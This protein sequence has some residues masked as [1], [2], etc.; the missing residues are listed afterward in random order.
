MTERPILFSGEMVRSIR[1]GRKTQTRRVGSF[2]KNDA[3]ELGV[4]YIGHAT[5]GTVAQATYRAFPKGGTAR[6]ALCEC[7]YGIPG[8]R[9]WVRET[10]LNNA[11]A[12][13][14]PVCF[15]R[16]DDADK[17]TDRKWKPAIFMPRSASRITLAIEALRAERVRDI[18]AHDAKAEG[19]Q[20]RPNGE[21]W[22]ATDFANLWDS[23]NGKKHPWRSN[24]WV[25]VIEFKDISN[26]PDQLSGDSNQKPK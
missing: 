12:G 13:Y 15:Y 5:K 19:I 10:W 3:T 4:D 17:P 20:L 8:D 2:Q 7:P 26:G 9:L 22:L 16:A 18:T 6:W 23:I 25:W 14:E 24:P 21:D 11:L 1:A